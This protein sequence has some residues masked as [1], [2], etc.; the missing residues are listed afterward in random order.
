MWVIIFLIYSSWM[1]S[2]V[3]H[4]SCACWPSYIFFGKMPIQVLCPFLIFFKI[5]NEFSIYFRYQSLIICIVCKYLLPFSRLPF[6]FVGFFCC[7]PIY[8]CFLDLAWGDIA[9]KILLRP[10]SKC[11]LPMFSSTSFVVLDLTFKFLQEGGDVT[12]FDIGLSNNFFGDFIYI[13]IYVYTHTHTHT[14]I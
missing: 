8:F 14:H 5:L 13:Y 11:V 10:M 6:H 12:H 4:L 2:D 3:E 1:I 9:K 7:S